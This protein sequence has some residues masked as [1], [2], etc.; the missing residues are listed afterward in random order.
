MGRQDL[1][2][3]SLQLRWLAKRYGF[4]VTE[5]HLEPAGDDASDD[6]ASEGATSHPSPGRRRQAT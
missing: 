5:F 6:T 2:E 1:E 4:A 3:L